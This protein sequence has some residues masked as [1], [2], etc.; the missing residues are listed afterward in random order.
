[1]P[2]AKSVRLKAQGKKHKDESRRP[3]EFPEHKA[4]GGKPT[5]PKQKAQG[6]NPE[7]KNQRQNT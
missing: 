6:K 4:Q 5:C 7:M 1:M 2:E 3:K